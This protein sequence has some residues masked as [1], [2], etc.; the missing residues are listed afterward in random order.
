MF[1]YKEI[2]IA[3]KSVGH[4]LSFIICDNTVVM[5]QV[6]NTSDRVS[7]QVTNEGQT[8]LVLSTY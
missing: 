4:K 7:T 8:Q 6:T 2:L 1:V 3:F 5:T